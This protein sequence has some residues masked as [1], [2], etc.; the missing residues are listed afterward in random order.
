MRLVHGAEVNLDR[1]RL[2]HHK[3]K[4]IRCMTTTSTRGR[5]REDI[6]ALIPLLPQEQHIKLQNEQMTTIVNLGS[7][8]D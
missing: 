4:M 2:M 1:W 3:Y 5:R 8:N 7:L 6:G